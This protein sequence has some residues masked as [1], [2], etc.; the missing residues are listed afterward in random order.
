[1]EPN[2]TGTRTRRRRTA[3]GA[4]LM[5]A[6]DAAS[7]R[8]LH[9]QV[10]DALRDAI[11]DGRIPPGG[12]LPSSRVLAA[13]LGVA[14]NTVMLAFDRLRVEGYLAGKRG[15]GTRVRTVIPD[16]TLAVARRERGRTAGARTPAP[17]AETA[18]P[19]APRL[20]GRGEILVAAGRPVAA[21]GG[22]KP[23]PFRIGIP[24]ADAFPA[25]AWARLA[26]RRWRQGRV[27]LGEIDAGGD[28]ELCAAI[29]EYVVNARGVR[30]TAAQVLV[31]TGTQQA[32]D[33]TARVLLEPG[34]AAWVEDPGYPG[35]RGALAAAGARLV[36]VPV[37]GEG[38]DVAAGERLA[39]D[40]RLACV[41]PSHQYPLGAVMSAPRRLALLAWARRA[42]A[43][44]FEDDY[45]SEFRYE[46]RP[47]PSLQGLDAEHRRPGEPA[48]VL[49]AGTFNKTLVP[50]LRL[51]YLVVPETLAEPLRSARAATDRHASSF[52]QGVLADFLGEGHYARHLRRVRALYAERQA[53]LLA[54]A[55][56]EGLSEHLALAPD[57]A[58][59]HLVG[60]L[61]PG[62]DDVAAAA[63]AREAGVE[64]YAIS[65]Y[66]LASPVPE[67]AR[68]LLLGYAAFTRDEIRDGVRRLAN[69]LE[70]W[71]RTEPAEGR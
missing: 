54:I 9:Q 33:L 20:S 48:R 39:A 62:T 15:G 50:G 58:G 2:S 57:P 29:A 71:R 68:G 47:L 51:G 65:R 16:T 30:C 46:G 12:R 52:E 5:V 14:R 42:D 49:Y 66:V 17:P 7:T 60:R 59:L 43:W 27:P 6:L 25:E 4:E 41:T 36:P 22:T 64:V 56:D 55:E 31:V 1:M 21:R 45:D 61:A 69:A 13:E 34:D 18:E 23:V 40:A 38:L 8:P 67:S 44:V 35:S 32:L 37:D 24:A 10:Y 28:P 19:R 53:E 11:L 63:A 26:A 70:K 3:G